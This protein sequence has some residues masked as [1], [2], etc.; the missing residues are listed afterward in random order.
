MGRHSADL[1][2]RR[3]AMGATTRQM[4]VGLG[5]DL[6]ELLAMEGGAASHDRLG[7]YAAWLS[8]LETAAPGRRQQMLKRAIYGMRFN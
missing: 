5:V 7:F 3:E 2:G 1:R 8:R 6:D 4:A